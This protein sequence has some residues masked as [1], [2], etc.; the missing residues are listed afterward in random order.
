M[1]ITADG[2]TA[3]LQTLGL[4]QGLFKPIPDVNTLAQNALSNTVN[5]ING[6]S[7]G[8]GLSLNSGFASIGNTSQDQPAEQDPLAEAEGSQ[9]DTADCN[10]EPY[11][12]LPLG[13]Q[14]FPPF[15]QTKANVYRYRQQQSVNLGSW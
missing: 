11:D 7:S 12:A 13:D 3:I 6:N 9:S 15:D 1:L 14:T 2:F 10:V 8:V 5:T 4:T